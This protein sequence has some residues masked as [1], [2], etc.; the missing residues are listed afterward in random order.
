MVEPPA[1]TF[2]WQLRKRR[3]GAGLTHE[4]L[5]EASG[6]AVRTIS[7]LERRVILK[8]RPDT[9]ARL[10]DALK[11]TGT[12][13]AEFAAAARERETAARMLPRGIAS[14]TG[15]ESELRRLTST[16]TGAGAAVGAGG[17]VGVAVIG[18]MAGVGKTS[19][20][21]CAAHQIADQFPDGQ[22]FLDLHGYADGLDPLTAEAALGSL[23]RSLGIPPEVIPEDLQERAAFYRSH[24]AGTRTL[25]V[26][27]N[28]LS[29][30]QVR[31]LLP[32]TGGCL[33]IVTSR[34]SLSGLDDA[35]SVDLEVL[36]EPEAIELFATIAGSGRVPADHRAVAEIVA[37]CG[38]LPLAVRIIAARLSYRKALSLED[39]AGQLRQEHGRLTHLQDEDRS[40][41]AV[42]ASSYQHL[43]GPEQ[44][45]FRHL[46]LI[47]GPDFD[48]CAA[49]SLDAADLDVAR[50]LLDSL[51]DHNLL[52]QRTPGRYRFH[53]LVRAYARTLSSDPG[54]GDGVVTPGHGP[55]AAG[56]SATAEAVDRLLD[57]YLATAQIA[58]RYFERRIPSSG[59]PVIG[60]VPVAGPRIDTAEQAQAWVG[61]ELANLDAAVHYAAGHRRPAHAIALAAAL[62][63]YLRA[64][65][66][67]AQALAL[68]QAA[69]DA[70]RDSGD[71]RGQAGAL[72]HLST[73]QWLT[74]AF[75][76]AQDSLTEAL[77][78][79]RDLGDRR[80]QAGLLT[81]LAI[82][83][84]L[85]GRSQEAATSVAAA[86]ELYRDLGDRHGQAG[87]LAEL[88]VVQRQIGEFALAEA[89]LSAALSLYRGL[90]NRLGEA[91][92]RCYLGSVQW[93]A[94]AFERAQ[95]T[96][97][98]VMDLY[99]ELGDRLGRAN[100]L[101]YLGAVQ[102]ANGAY[103]QATHS[104]TGAL[105]LYS[106]LGERRGRAGALAYLGS[107]QRL[108][109]EY[110]QADDSLTQ[111]LDLFRELRDRGG[112]A[113][114]LNYH[115]ALA[116]AMGHPALARARYGDALRLARDIGSRKDEADALD[117]IATSYTS[118]GSF[119]A[120]GTYLRQALALYE[121]LGCT[122]DAI[123][124][125]AALDPT[126][127]TGSLGQPCEAG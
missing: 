61:A 29:T 86:L 15:R 122:T 8:P 30:A 75:G 93:A 104:L 18:G 126:Q 89:S 13:R 74:A 103:E 106:E 4:K 51:L 14:F 16:A 71:R 84:R 19:L 44:Q 1:G 98:G 121:S 79:Y 90:G 48:A 28:A 82:V 114:T 113:E 46:G 42:F 37:L 96:L 36:P 47:C 27:D 24:L 80:G 112:E 81:E 3:L 76:G 38:Y 101:L 6:V 7:D 77:G 49:A 50:R 64:H 23:L 22:L 95:D 40:I 78:L 91:G 52:I 118:E 87:A 108:T 2:A 83:Q 119:V 11:L 17:T 127:V 107:A 88:G 105:D 26:L 9:V 39:L 124:V 111:A 63:Q 68:H 99:R 125:Q 21:V 34:K 65:G 25:I 54:T 73:V 72:A 35:Q 62:A 69:L 12:A 58:D 123:R 56:D 70:A 20:A 31:P 66:P 32:G 102:R 97:A 92:T 100:T 67:W 45:M 115:A 43:P 33:V 59:E 109:A 120:A 5:A 53:D 85:T 117:G 57:F 41:T 10:A 60:R 94:G 55:Q 116:D 110:E